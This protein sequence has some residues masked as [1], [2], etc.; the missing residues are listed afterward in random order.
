MRHFSVAGKRGRT[1]TEAH[2]AVYVCLIVLLLIKQ[3]SDEATIM[4]SVSEVNVDI[5]D[6]L[7]SIN[8]EQ[9][10]S[11]FREFGFNTVKDCAAIDDSVLH[12]IG[13][14]PTGH[15]R[16]I[17]KQLQIILSKMQDIPIYANIHKI[18]KNEE[19]SKGHPAPS[20]GQ[21]TCVERSDSSG[22]QTP[23]PA[24]LESVTKNLDQSDISVGNSQFP[25]SDDEPSLPKH[26]FPIPEEGHLKLGSFQD[27]L[28]GSENIEIESL[29]PK[30][31]VDCTAKEQQTG[32]VDVNSED[33]NQLPHV[34]AGRLSS[35]GCSASDA[36][37][38]HGTNGLLERSPPSPLFNFQGQ[39]VLND[40]YVPSSPFLTPMRSRS[41][42][43]SRPSRSFLLRH[44]PVPEIPG[45]T[46]GI[47]GR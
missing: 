25:K 45:S 32:Q 20:S 15:R 42:L 9:Y 12:E 30:E 4:S 6:F 5:Q 27:S 36:S 22:V 33:V 17:I 10:V 44:R 1:N 28:L 35:L 29:V 23:S 11:H 43:V 26:S 34:D 21:D 47:S 40:L 16:R 46:K 3:L 31:P 19:T 18:K 39:M 7:M 2:P 41:K 38:G 14:S 37:S 8:L 24:Q 13:I